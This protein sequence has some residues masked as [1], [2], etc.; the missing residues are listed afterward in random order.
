MVDTC[1][2][3][4]ELIHSVQHIFLYFYLYMGV[5]DKHSCLGGGT[6]TTGEHGT[7][8]SSTGAALG[9]PWSAS[10]AWPEATGDGTG[11]NSV[12]PKDGRVKFMKASSSL[13]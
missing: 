2:F 12:S 9:E 5:L 4:A 1:D 7:G 13:S 3:E 6:A 8:V 10:T 11:V